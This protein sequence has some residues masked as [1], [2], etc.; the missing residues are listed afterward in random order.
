MNTSVIAAT[1]TMGQLQKKIDTISHNIANVNTH[2]FKRRE[3]SFSDLL[4]QQVNNQI[5]P[6]REVGRLTPNGL[7]VGSGAM[8]A[9]TAIRMD[10]G[11]IQVTDRAL[12]VAI[13]EKGQFFQIAVDVDGVLDTRYTRDG[14]F[15]VTPT[16]ENNNVLNLVT[17]RGDFVL[18]ENGPITIPANFSDIE[19]DPN[20]RVTVLFEGGLTEQVG[21][22]ELVQIE[23]P[24]QLIQ[25]GDNTLAIP[26]NLAEQGLVLADIINFLPVANIAV[27]QRAL[28]M[29]NVNMSR[30]MSEL[31]LAQ[32]TF[33]F[34][35]R[36]I[37]MADQMMGLVNS[38][39]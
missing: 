21:R 38:I 26:D 25:V 20:G 34:N 35:A 6:S 13:L 37:S 10:Q 22:L 27:Q 8:L 29:S 11:S 5:D 15:Y 36:S 28:E 4:F 24:Q 9:Q 39:R 12:D 14:A 19:I 18:G 31:L 32:R 7:R 33:Q 3:T 16:P 17:S 2:G 1:V 23:R 30:E